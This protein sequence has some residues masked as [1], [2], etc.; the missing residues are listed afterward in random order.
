MTAK[1]DRLAAA[2]QAGFESA[3]LHLITAVGDAERG[4]TSAIADLKPVPNPYRKHAPEP[5]A[6]PLG[7]SDGGTSAGPHVRAPEWPDA[8]RTSPGQADES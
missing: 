8:M 6:H 2:W 5:A 7:D 1:N 4:K 3:L